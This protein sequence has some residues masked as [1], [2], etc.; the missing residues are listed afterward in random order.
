MEKSKKEDDTE[1]IFYKLKTV[2]NIKKTK[3]A[4][5]PF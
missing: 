1:L 2:N 4:K 3:Q 5:V